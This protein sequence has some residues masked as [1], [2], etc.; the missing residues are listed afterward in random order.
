M[1]GF[2]LSLKICFCESRDLTIK[3]GAKYEV[4]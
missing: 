2:F 3:V 4:N 1:R